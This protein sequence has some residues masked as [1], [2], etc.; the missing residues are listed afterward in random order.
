[1]IPA[2]NEASALAS[3]LPEIVAAADEV[4]VSDGGSEDLTREVAVDC[5]ARVVCGPPGRG[6]QLNRGARAA[7]GDGLLFLHADT[8]LPEG[9]VRS[10]ADALANG[11]IGGGFQIRFASSRPIYRLGSRI[12]NLRTRWS[13]SPLGDQAQFVSRTAFEELGGYPDWPILEDLEFM[14]RLKRLGRITILAPP[15]VT[16][17]RRFEDRGITR[18]IAFNWLIFA[19]YFAGVSPERLAR[20]Y[21][22]V[23]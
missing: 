22:D 2:L 1:M 23:R 3:N 7:R 6:P 8:V 11:S 15:V 20:L 13:R 5:G 12:V 21:R 19:L 10:V 14:R 4:L 16:S 9:A 17:A 18:T